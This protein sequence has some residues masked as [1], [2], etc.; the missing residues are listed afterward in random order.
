[1]TAPV[2]S[3]DAPEH[4]VPRPAASRWGKGRR[5]GLFVLAFVTMMGVAVASM[6]RFV[7]PIAEQPAA[8]VEPA[9]GVE[10]VAAPSGLTLP[11]AG[12]A[13]RDVR[14]TWGQARDGGARGHTGTD[15]MAPAGTPVLAAASGTIEKLFDSRAGGRTIYL[16]SPDRRWSFY[17]AHLSG[18][19]PR[20]AE[21]QAVRAAQPIG[22]VGD[23]GN[24]GAGNFH[25]HFGISRMRAQDRWW[26]GEPVNPYPLLAGSD[27]GR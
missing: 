26:E 4:H 18:Y 25:L 6:V 15:I 12:V 22:F 7:G 11:V 8:R 13:W 19:A 20:L 14:D 3:G 21:G 27:A 9:A 24:A 5:F 16:R 1:M 2:V 23:T 17:Y 10:A